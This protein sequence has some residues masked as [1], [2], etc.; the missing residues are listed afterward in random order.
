MCSGVHTVLAAL[1]GMTSA[2]GYVAR[3]SRET[4]RNL[5]S[6]P[7]IKP[8]LIPNARDF[9]PW[10][11]LPGAGSK[12]GNTTSPSL[13]SKNQS[14]VSFSDKGSNACAALVCMQ[15]FHKSRFPALTPLPSPCTRVPNVPP[16]SFHLLQA[17][18]VSVAS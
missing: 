1:L 16:A 10:P 18:E 7:R 17:P 14:Y 6:D 2:L 11:R 3:E 15:A 13:V 5:E 4:S 8:D 9:K 12:P